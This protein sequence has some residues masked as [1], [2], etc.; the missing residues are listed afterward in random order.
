MGNGAQ[1]IPSWPGAW[2]P[3]KAEYI[4]ADQT[5]TLIFR[6]RQSGGPYIPVCLNARSRRSARCCKR[7]DSALRLIQRTTS[8]APQ[9]RYVLHR[10]GCS[11][12]D[13]QL[14]REGLGWLCVSGRQDRLEQA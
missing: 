3:T 10:T 6:L 13:D 8:E 12:E 11:Q 1:R 9:R 14:L 4:C 2:T 5:A 7:L